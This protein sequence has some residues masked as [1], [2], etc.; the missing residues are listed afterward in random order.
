MGDQNAPGALQLEFP[1]AAGQLAAVRRQVREWLTGAGMA[2]DRVCDLLLAV[3]EACA[4]AIE[5]GHLGDQRTICLHARR[6]CGLIR[7]TIADQ[8]TWLARDDRPDAWRGNPDSRRGRGLALMR[9]LVPDTRI[10]ITDNGTIVEFVTP[11]PQSAALPATRSHDL[12]ADVS[13]CD[14]SD[15]VAE[16][17][18][19]PV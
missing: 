1:A 17:S 6:D 4:N 10:E 14:Q 8:G 16:N 3:D 15:R 13:R 5:H 2:S 12:V 9:A 7:I 18:I 19:R 11:A